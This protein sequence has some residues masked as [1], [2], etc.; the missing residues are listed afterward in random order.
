[1]KI[2]I[3]LPVND[4]NLL[5]QWATG[6]ES[7][8]FSTL[9]MYDRLVWHNPEALTTLAFLGGCTS[10]IGL[11]TQ[12]LLAPLRNTTSRGVQAATL[13]RLTGGRFTLGMGVG[14]DR[15]DDFAAA[16]AELKGRGARFDQQITQLRQ[17]WSQHPGIG[18][19]P[20]TPGGPTILVGGISER[21]VSRVARLAVGFISALPPAEGG[22]LIDIVNHQWTDAGRPG[23]PRIVGQLNAALG[24]DAVVDEAKDALGAYYN[25]QGLADFQVEHLATTRQQIQDTIT[26]YADL[27]ADE[28]IAFCWSTDSSQLD[29]LAEVA[30]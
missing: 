9:C 14:G 7:I 1:M 2:G 21:A 19:Q 16:G 24:P 8:G 5:P 3:G 22:W 11:Q 13:D 27:G 25:Q 18:P 15:P 12:V 17:Q 30:L 26:G 20:A 29:R 4:P 23:R 10:R 6:A 28:V